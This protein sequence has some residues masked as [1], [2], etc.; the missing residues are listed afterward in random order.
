MQGSDMKQRRLV[1]EE[2]CVGVAAKFRAYRKPLETAASFNY[3]GRLLIVTDDEL[4]A[5]II[6]LK[7][8]RKSWYIF[9]RILGREMGNPKTSGLFYLEVVQDILLFGS[10][11]WVVTPRMG[12]F[13]GSFHHS[14]AIILSVMQPKRQTDG[15]W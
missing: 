1:D 2:V 9:Y 13:L 4:S 6:N 3:I 7:K 10:E 11:M 8:V 5:V 12:R 14:M 15:R